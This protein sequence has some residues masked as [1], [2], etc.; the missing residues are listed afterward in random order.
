MSANWPLTA[1]PAGFPS[2][3]ERPVTARL[4][5]YRGSSEGLFSEPTA[6]AWPRPR[7]PR[8]QLNPIFVERTTYALASRL[9][10]SWMEGEG[11]GGGQVWSRF[12][13]SL[14]ETLIASE[15]G[16]GALDHPAERQGH[17]AF[18]V[19]VPFDDLEQPQA[20][21]RLS[22]TANS[23]CLSGIDV[24]W[25]KIV[26]AVQRAVFPS[27][28]DFARVVLCGMVSEHHLYSAAAR[29]ELDDGG[30]KNVCGFRASSSVI[31]A[32]CSPNTEYRAMASPMLRASRLRCREDI[33][34]GLSNAPA[35][36]IGLLQGGRNFGKLLAPDPTRGYRS[37][38]D[39]VIPCR[40][41]LACRVGTR[42]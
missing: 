29:R 6:V 33:V 4:S 42:P 15:P 21:I 22:L 5:R 34:E 38:R 26:G 1:G 10:A 35:A 3:D 41:A 23:S 18:H 30:L 37:M 16:E 8:H 32:N 11:P 28:D 17:K 27:L 31:S 14:G 20:K 19:G 36:F 9:R 7:E 25:E 24:Y 2:S 12:A 13:K 40:T 39:R